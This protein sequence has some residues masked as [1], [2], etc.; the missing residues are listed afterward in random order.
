MS[1]AI[2]SPAFTQGAAIPRQFTGDG[3]DLSPPLI[4]TEPP[5]GTKAFALICDDPDAPKGTFTHWIVFNLPAETRELPEGAGSSAKLPEGTCQGTNDFG[6]V[7]YGG[8]APPPGKP[9]RYF[10]RLAALDRPLDLKPRAIRSEVL[11]ALKS[12]ILAESD[13]MGTYGR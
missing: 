12:H 4:W 1:F 2:T 7:R 9:H 5:P 13:L 3:S 11:S 10:F 8:P 6:R